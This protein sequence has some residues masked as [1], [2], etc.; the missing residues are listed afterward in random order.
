MART[1]ARAL[2]ETCGALECAGRGLG[3]SGTV[4][5]FCLHV[6]HTR[7]HEKRGGELR[8]RGGE[9]E[10]KLTCHANGK[11]LTLTTVSRRK[12]IFKMVF[13]DG[14]LK[15]ALMASAFEN[16]LRA[17][18]RVS[19]GAEFGS[20]MGRDIMVF[21]PDRGVRFPPRLLR[22]SHNSWRR[23]RRRMKGNNLLIWRLSRQK[24]KRQRRGNQRK[25]KPVLREKP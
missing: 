10:V 5:G 1:G 22:E 3:R 4:G 18:M 23:I 20:R 7:E 6:S 8:R 15:G 14:G 12:T 17:A 19:A 21:V 9:G 16:L 25:Y 11:D 13:H 24:K 2:D